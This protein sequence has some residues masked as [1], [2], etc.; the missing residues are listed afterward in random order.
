MPATPGSAACSP[1]PSAGAQNTS[2]AAMV[3]A[4]TGERAQTSERSTVMQIR[5]RRRGQRQPE[6]PACSGRR[7]KESPC[8][9]RRGRPDECETV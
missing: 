7:V 6:T 9:E 1:G 5:P 4:P 2:T 3:A 8:H